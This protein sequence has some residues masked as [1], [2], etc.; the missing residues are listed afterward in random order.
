M[1]SSG[2]LQVKRTVGIQGG[3]WRARQS[4]KVRGDNINLSHNHPVVIALHQITH[5]PHTNQMLFSPV[6]FQ[7]SHLTKSKTLIIYNQDRHMQLQD[8]VHVEL[9]TH[10]PC[11]FNKR[12]LSLQ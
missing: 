10:G 2:H 8:C 7:S 11:K 6:T 9:T 5:S 12:L 3:S 4:I 1:Q